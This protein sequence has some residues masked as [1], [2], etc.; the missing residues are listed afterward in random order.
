MHMK[1][2]ENIVQ[3]SATSHYVKRDR[4]TLRVDC[5]ILYHL[6]H[7]NQVFEKDQ[8]PPRRRARPI[9]GCDARLRTIHPDGPRPPKRRPS[10]VVVRLRAYSHQR[11]AF[12]L[13][14]K[15]CCGYIKT[16]IHLNGTRWRDDVLEAAWSSPTEKTLNGAAK[17][18]AWLDPWPTAN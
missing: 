3:T 16:P 8:T 9:D 11:R 2:C 1:T 4:T 5:T 10:Q 13:L 14:R 17:F 12:F 7:R 6:G 15:F 18:H